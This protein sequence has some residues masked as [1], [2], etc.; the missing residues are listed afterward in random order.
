MCALPESLAH[1][2]FQKSCVLATTSIE[3]RSIFVATSQPSIAFIPGLVLL[4]TRPPT[5]A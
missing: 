4:G 2:R 5:T 3:I 1:V